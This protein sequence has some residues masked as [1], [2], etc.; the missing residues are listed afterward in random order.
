MKRFTLAALAIFSSAIVS[1]CGSSE[2]APPAD[3]A[4]TN[5]AIAEPPSPGSSGPRGAG[6]DE[7]T[8]EVPDEA[9]IEAETFGDPPELNT[10]E[11]ENEGK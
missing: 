8:P 9:V 7:A 2:E 6:P 3:T 1:A 11:E 4:P 10:S 5:A